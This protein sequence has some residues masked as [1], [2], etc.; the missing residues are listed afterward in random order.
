M[1]G[2][3]TNGGL[4]GTTVCRMFITGVTPAGAGSDTGAAAG[5]TSTEMGTGLGLAAAPSR[6]GFGLALTTMSTV[7]GSMSGGALAANI[8]FGGFL[9][10]KE[11]VTTPRANTAPPVAISAIPGVLV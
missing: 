11:K 3:S 2:G 6:L 7:T 10:D 4:G 5:T 1:G 8:G 9:N